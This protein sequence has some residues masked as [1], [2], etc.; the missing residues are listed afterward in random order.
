VSG[1]VC[2]APNAASQAARRFTAAVAAQYAGAADYRGKLYDRHR[3]SIKN[4]KS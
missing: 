4:Y 1:A 3:A 2:I